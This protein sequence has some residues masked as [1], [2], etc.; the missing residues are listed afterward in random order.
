VP[1]QVGSTCT[2][3][4]RSN[5]LVQTAK[6]A[7]D[8]E[9]KDSITVRNMVQCAM[10]SEEAAKARELQN[11]PWIEKYRPTALKDVVSHESIK[12]VIRK[13]VQQ[14]RMP[15]LLFHGPPGTG[16]TTTVLA[17]AKELYGPHYS[18]MV[19]ELNASDARGID[20]VRDQIQSFAST[21]RICATNFKIVVLDECDSMTKDAQFA[22]RRVIEK[23]SRYTRFCLICNYS[24]KIIPAVQSRCTKFRFAP[25]PREHSLLTLQTI[26]DTE[27]VKISTVSL[28]LL[29]KLGSGDMRRTVNM[30]QSCSLASNGHISEETIHK[31]VGSI[32]PG[33]SE[34]LFR[35]LLGDSVTS[36]HAELTL[37]KQTL[38]LS[39]GDLIAPLCECVLQAHL[40]KDARITLLSG[41]ADIEY[42][43]SHSCSEESQLRSLVSLFQGIRFER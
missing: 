5:T 23:Y 27:N 36:C 32:S 41:L 11:L 26:A 33:A 42:S 40:L 10:F 25:I 20:V 15:H 18:S 21:T 19:L 17:L 12:E 8:C 31:T 14:N 38:G 16:K 28:Q 22:L 29:Q 3:G 24:S 7:H 34:Q 37:L 30:L 43:L 35:L 9:R 1:L 39:L 6:S 4:Q 13:F 2:T